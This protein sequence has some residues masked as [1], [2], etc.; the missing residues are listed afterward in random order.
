[1]IEM[2][3]AHFLTV[4]IIVGSIMVTPFYILAVYVFSGASAHKGLLAGAVF[5]IWGSLMVWICL[6]QIP[7]KSGFA[8]NLIVPFFLD[9]AFFDFVLA[10]RMVFK[11]GT[12]SKMAGRP[13]AV[14]GHRCSVSD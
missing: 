8:G 6:H 3:D 1:M 9:L 7:G 11:S 12:V 13:A 4:V 5:L 10:K 2:L 14:S